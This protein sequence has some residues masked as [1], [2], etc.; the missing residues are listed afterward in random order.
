MDYKHKARVT[1]TADFRHFDF[2]FGM[3]ESNIRLILLLFIFFPLYRL[4]YSL[5]LNV[6]SDLRDL[7]K[8]IEDSKARIDLLG[9]Y[10]PEGHSIVRDPY[11][12]SGNEMFEEV[13]HQ[14]VRCCDAFLKQMV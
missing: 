7:E 13:Y 8:M 9:S 2:I 12:E 4:L 10:D 11:Y 14:C 6:F 5:N 3:D 1:S